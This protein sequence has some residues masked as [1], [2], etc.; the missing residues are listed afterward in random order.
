MLSCGAILLSLIFSFLIFPKIQDPLRL[1]PD[2]DRNGELARNIYTGNGYVYE[3]SSF[4]AIDRGP[5]YPYVLAGL[6]FVTGGYHVETV[7]IFQVLIHGLTC[8]L[9]F[10]LA[11]KIFTRRI[12]IIA[13]V[14]CALHPM[15]IWYTARI[16]I[17]TLHTFL[18]IVAAFAIV[19]FIE[20]LTLKRAIGAGLAL[21]IAV[22]TKSILMFFPFVVGGYVVL[23]WKRE[24]FK[25]VAV[26]LIVFFLTVTPWTIRNYVV[27][28]AFVPVHTSLGL[29]LI[30]GDA[31]AQHITEIPF[32][33]FELWHFGEEKIDSLLAGTNYTKTDP[34]GDR[35][36][37]SAS[38]NYNVSHPMFLIKRTFVNFVT[39]WY[40]SESKLKSVFLIILQIPLLILTSIA[41]VRLWREH[42]AVRPLILLTVY[43]VLL[44]SLVVGWARYSVPIVPLCLMLI[45]FVVSEIWGK[46]FMKSGKLTA[47]KG[48]SSVHQ[49][50]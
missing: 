25:P 50:S 35:L 12:A 33:N 10:F 23:T 44:H 28:G 18:I 21:G 45:A 9:I 32:S 47:E 29:N 2:P 27:T 14:L 37:A 4:P 8:L 46:Y 11:Q 48:S 38:L 1:N 34:D 40:L 42:A 41:S 5:V 49:N 30:Q 39:F 6:F 16:W 36:L 31:I 22:L 7:Q 17:E 15:L 3:G 24:S 26:F 13:Q 20:R 43:Y 19:L